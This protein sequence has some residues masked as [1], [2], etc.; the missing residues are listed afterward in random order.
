M[1]ASIDELFQK[2]QRNGTVTIE[3]D[4]WVVIGQLLVERA[5]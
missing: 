4:T 1:L 3:H 2:H 5:S